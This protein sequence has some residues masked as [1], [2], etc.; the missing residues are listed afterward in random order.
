[1]QFGFPHTPFKN[2][3][4]GGYEKALRAIGGLFYYKTIQKLPFESFWEIGVQG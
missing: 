1:L 3:K 2:L 4:K